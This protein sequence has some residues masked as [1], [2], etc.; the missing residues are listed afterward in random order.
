[1]AAGE[2]LELPDGGAE[3]G[4]V[5]VGGSEELI[6]EFDGGRLDELAGAGAEV[7]GGLVLKPVE[8]VD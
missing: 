8:A 5:T 7:E 1:M 3:G 4:A 2:E 6:P